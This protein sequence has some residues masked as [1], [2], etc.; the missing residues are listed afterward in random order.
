MHNKKVLLCVLDGFGIAPPSIGN[1]ITLASA[2]YINNLFQSYPST[3]LIT[4][5]SAVGLPHDQMGN[6]EV[7]HMTISAGRVIQ[8]DLLLIEDF[9]QHN[10]RQSLCF[11]QLIASGQAQYIHIMCMISDGGVHSHIQHLLH[12]INALGSANCKVWLHLITDG[13]DVLPQSAQQY[14]DQIQTVLSQWCNISIATLSGRYYAMDRDQRHER[15]TL[16]LDAFLGKG[17]HGSIDNI[18]E[19][20]YIAGITDEFFKPI[21]SLEYPGFNKGDS[22]V[23]LNFRSDRVKQ[24]SQAIF[25]S[26]PEQS[27]ALKYSLM[28]GVHPSFVSMIQ[29]NRP[30]NTLGEIISRQGL[31]QLRIAE[32]EKYPHVTYFFN[33]G[34]ESAFQGEDRI[35][36]PSP[37]VATYD[38][39]PQMSAFELTDRLCAE[40]SKDAYQFILVNYANADMV[41]HTGNLA[42][43]IQAI[44]VIDECLARLVPIAIAHDYVICITSDHGN[45]ESIIE[46]DKIVTSHTK[47]P[48]PF[49]LINYNCSNLMQGTLADIAPT[50]LKIFNID[51]PCD[52]Q[53]RCLINE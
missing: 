52:M 34:V 38:L 20:N 17:F 50:I 45:A 51:V 11:Q 16:Y 29:Q 49:L 18:V 36:V 47:N 35:L 26:I 53:G 1:A 32:T 37:R 25:A 5:G 15:T 19:Q 21:Q 4:H 22:F 31:Q 28:S 33:G 2:H 44:E 39:V 40:L 8:Q 24:I 10:L 27:F 30:I 7:G 23:M 46:H 6:S 14:I 42:S 3:Q 48:V 41:G 43:T 12:I 13:R 9:L